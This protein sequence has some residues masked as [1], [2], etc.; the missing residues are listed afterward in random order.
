VSDPRR[1]KALEDGSAKLNKLL[2][3]AM[4]DLASDALTDGRRFPRP[5]GP[6]SAVQ[7]HPSG[8]IY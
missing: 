1:L 7:L 6:S 5:S 3:E 2:A 4:L 8:R